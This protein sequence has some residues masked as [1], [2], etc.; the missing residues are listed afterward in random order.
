MPNSPSTAW[1]RIRGAQQV[2]RNPVLK[3]QTKQACFVLKTSSQSDTGFPE[4]QPVFLSKKDLECHVFLQSTCHVEASLRALSPET[5][6]AAWSQ[7]AGGV[8]T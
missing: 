7:G 6:V 1:G 2:V 4:S 3:L 8:I 5:M